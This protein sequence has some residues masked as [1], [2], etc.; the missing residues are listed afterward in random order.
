M[1]RTPNRSHTRRIYP[2][3]GLFE[4]VHAYTDHS[5]EANSPLLERLRQ[6]CHPPPI[7]FGIK[8]LAHASDVSQTWDAS[9][10][11]PQRISEHREVA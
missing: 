9:K 4:S 3:R 5:H 2:A 8:P 6:P 1:E 11:K 7:N 10:S